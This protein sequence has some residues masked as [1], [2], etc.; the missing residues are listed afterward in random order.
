MQNIEVH[1]QP[2]GVLVSGELLN[3]DIAYTTALG[4]LVIAYAR[5]N[6]TSLHYGIAVPRSDLP[7]VMHA[8]VLLFISSVHDQE[9]R[10][11]VFT[12]ERNGL[13]FS[14]SASVRFAQAS[15]GKANMYI[16]IMHT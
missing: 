3:A 8:E 7:G 9:Y 5:N 6:H 12:I 4:F 1:Y 14:R 11:S 10:V 13:P 16:I 2:N 15:V